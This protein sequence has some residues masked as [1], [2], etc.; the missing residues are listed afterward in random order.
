MTGFSS[1]KNHASLTFPCPFFMQVPQNNKRWLAD[2]ASTRDGGAPARRA[3]VEESTH[4]EGEEE[5]AKDMTESKTDE[6]ID[7]TKACHLE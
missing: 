2:P 4:T 1:F 6:K 3:K 7:P 5:K